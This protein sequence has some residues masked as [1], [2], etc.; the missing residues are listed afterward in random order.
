MFYI[1]ND[2]FNVL[3][4]KAVCN[5]VRQILPPLPRM[6]VSTSSNAS[7]HS[8]HSFIER[9]PKRKGG[10]LKLATSKYSTPGRK[11]APMFQKKFVLLNYMGPM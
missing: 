3:I 7:T 11:P 4:D 6:G 2:K 9:R 1:A 10:K 8:F 5:E